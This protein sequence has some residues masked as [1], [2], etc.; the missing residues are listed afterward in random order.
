[1]GSEIANIIT[2]SKVAKAEVEKRYKITSS[3]NLVLGSV[4]LDDKPKQFSKNLLQFQFIDKG[5]Y[6]SDEISKYVYTAYWVSFSLV[7]GRVESIGPS[8][9][10]TYKPITSD[11]YYK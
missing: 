10:G 4:L 11:E 3:E 5:H 7:T 1:M 9:Y 2:M 8:T 6:R